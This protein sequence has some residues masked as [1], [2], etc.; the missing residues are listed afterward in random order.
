MW[1]IA[2]LMYKNYPGNNFIQKGTL[3]IDQNMDHPLYVCI[4]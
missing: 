2:I 1:K 4:I 3:N